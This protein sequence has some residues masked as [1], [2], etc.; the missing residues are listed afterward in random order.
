MLAD[1]LTTSLLMA[2]IV[3]VVT[4]GIKSALPFIKAVNNK[5]GSRITAAIVGIVLCITTNLGILNR[6]RIDIS[7]KLLDYIITGIIISRGANAVHDISSA[8]Y[9]NNKKY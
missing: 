4:N 8:F 5:N 3:E 9:R 1:S 7:I 2:V 6:L